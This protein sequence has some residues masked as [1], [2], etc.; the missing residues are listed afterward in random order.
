MDTKE[1]FGGELA[2]QVPVK[3]VYDDVAHPAL[4]EVGKALQGVTRMALAPVSAMVWG[5]DKIASYLDVAI[6]EYFAR[7]KIASEKIKSPDPS[8]AVPTIMALTYN[9][10]KAELREMFTNLLGASMNSDVVDEHP[11]FVEIIKQLCSDEGK[12]LKEIYKR[13]SLPIIKFRLSIETV[14]EIDVLPYFSDI[15]Y[16]V[17]CEY[18]QKFP[19]YLDNLHR[20]GLVDVEVDRHFV[21]N[22]YYENLKKHPACKKIK[23][24]TGQRIVEVKSI[25]EISAFGRKFCSVCME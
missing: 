13:G 24:Q 21:N 12:M 14:G 9:S 4:S 11:A 20:H 19:E 23:V 10:H 15:C 2:K 25:Y 22:E 17:G 8:I 3:A 1:S 5:F 6:P 16:C 18:P 7:K